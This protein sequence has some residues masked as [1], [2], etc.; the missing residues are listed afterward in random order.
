MDFVLRI[1]PRV[2]R[3]MIAHAQAE[4]PKECVGFLAGT[5]E[6]VVTEHLPLVNRLADPRRFESEG[7]SQLAAEKRCRELGLR[8]LAV[9]HSH[10][11]SPPIPSRTDTDP[12]ENLW[13]GQPVV[14]LIISLAGLEPEV[15]AWWLEPHRYRPAEWTVLPEEEARS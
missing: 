1:P 5:S 6:G 3:A 7:K 12:D 15:Q 13:V 14:S 11:T 2:Y 8:I 4:S 9:Y 10:P